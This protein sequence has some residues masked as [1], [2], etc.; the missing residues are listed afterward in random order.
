MPFASSARPFPTD[1]LSSSPTAHVA[2]PRRYPPS[3]AK[4]AVEVILI[5]REKGIRTNHTWVLFVMAQLL[6]GTAAEE[7][8]CDDTGEKI[9]IRNSVFASFVRSNKDW[10][11][12]KNPGNRES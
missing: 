8:F 10:F 4:L 12:F 5:G 2:L 3:L 11:Q 1:T 7:S 9:F 6:V